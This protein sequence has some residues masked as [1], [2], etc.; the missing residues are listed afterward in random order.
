MFFQALSLSLSSYSIMVFIFNS[1]FS[2][3]FTIYYS[4]EHALS[5]DK[6]ELSTHFWVFFLP[7]YRMKI[8]TTSS[9]L[10]S[11]SSFFLFKLLIHTHHHDITQKHTHTQLDLNL[12]HKQTKCT[13]IHAVNPHLSILLYPMRTEYNIITTST[14]EIPT[15]FLL[16]CFFAFSFF[17]NS[18]SCVFF[19]CRSCGC[20]KADVHR[21]TTSF[22]VCD[23]HVKWW[24]C[25][26]KP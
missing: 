18:C 26:D 5:L 6:S 24:Y 25:I 14:Y 1:R 17:F 8:T 11:M 15:R 20:K 9:L 23:D 2:P 13:H 12:L 7:T 19:L 16:C 10:D 4:T 21:H 22:V 3:Q